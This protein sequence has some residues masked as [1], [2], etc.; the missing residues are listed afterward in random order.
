MTLETITK[1]LSARPRGTYLRLVLGTICG[2]SFALFGSASLSIPLWLTVLLAVLV[3]AAAHQIIGTTLPNILTHAFSARFVSPAREVAR[4]TIFQLLFFVVFF[5]VFNLGGSGAGTFSEMYL[6]HDVPLNGIY[7]FM[8]I[9]FSGLTLLAMLLF[10]FF[11]FGFRSVTFYFIDMTAL[12]GALLA[13][14]V[15]SGAVPI[16]PFW[17]NVASGMT[18]GM[19]CTA[20][21][22][23]Q[24]EEVN[25]KSGDS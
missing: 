6:V 14:V 15:A 10:R 4:H 1:Q 17:I 21:N 16:Y 18:F 12:L 8:V 19:L 7:F 22:L 5:I 3:A 23:V 24:L 13:L 9:L 11:R 2:G 20:P 25:R